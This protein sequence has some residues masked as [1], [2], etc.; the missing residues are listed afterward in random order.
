MPAG[1]PPKPT[2]QK[3][4]EGNRGRRPL[5]L[6]EPDFQPGAPEMPPGMTKPAQALWSH[7]TGL[8][9]PK[10]VLTVADG[11]ALRLLCVSEARLEKLDRMLDRKG[12]T[13]ES[14]TES[15]GKMIRPRPEVAMAEQLWRQVQRQQVEFGLT[16]SSRTKVKAAPEAKK[17]K[18]R[19]LISGA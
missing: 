8:L 2:E 4:A 10:R 1:R 9:V 15:G 7:Y 19:D 14:R 11:R 13:Y 17:S 18:L 6:L 16:P 3:K 12:L 5:N